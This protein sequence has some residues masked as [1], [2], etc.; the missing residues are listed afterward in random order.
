M[1]H[2]H[3]INDKEPV[4]GEL[5]CPDID[6]RVLAVIDVYKRQQ[7]FNGLVL[8]TLEIKFFFHK[9]NCVSKVN[10]VFLADTV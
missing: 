9:K 4:M 2:V 1:V 7:L 10:T 6:G 3:F 5:A 8:D